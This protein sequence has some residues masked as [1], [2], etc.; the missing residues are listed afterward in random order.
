MKK[1]YA[2]LYGSG[3]AE[4][5]YNALLSFTVN[6]ETKI[7]PTLPR[8]DIAKLLDCIDR[9]T[10]TGKR[11]YAVMMLGTVLGLRACDIIALKRTDIDWQKSEVKVVQSKTA[12][13]VVLPLTEDVSQALQDYLLNARPD[14]NE[15]HVFCE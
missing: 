1:L 12:N 10:K 8:D 5:D 14:T 9:K 3:R 4:S 7:Y 6:R 15:R 2:F 13:T 11:N